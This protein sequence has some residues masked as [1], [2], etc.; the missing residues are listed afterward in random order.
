MKRDA[1]R[2]F[3][4]NADHKVV[5]VQ[6]I[7]TAF[8]VFLIGGGLAMLMRLELARHGLQFLTYRQYDAAA[9]A[10]GI[11]MVAAV[12]AAASGIGNFIVPLQLG[13][14]G[15]ALP[16]ANALGFWLFLSAVAALLTAPV[17]GGPLFL[18]AVVAA[19]LSAILGGVNMLATTLT[20]RAGGMD[21]RRVPIF[22]WSMIATSLLQVVCAAAL[23]STAVWLVLRPAGADMLA[24]QRLLRFCAHP[25]VYILLLPAFGAVLEILPAYCGKPLFARRP[26]AASL[27][28]IAAL[29]LVFG[30]CRILAPE[31][32]AIDAEWIAVPAGVVLLSALGTLWRAKIRLDAPMLWALAALANGLL[33]GLSGVPLAGA[34]IDL[35][36]RGTAFAAAHF[37]FTIMGVAVF[38]FLAAFH[39]WFP[40]MTGRRLNEALAKTQC[41][42]MFAGI[43]AVF[44]PL[45]WLGSHGMRRRA[46][47]FPA[48]MDPAQTFASSAALLIAA[49]ALVFIYNVC[50]S[51]ADGDAATEEPYDH[52]AQS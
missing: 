1:F 47:D 16:R 44:I 2:Y 14:R 22:A 41:A 40:M 3:S 11:A 12:F 38:G 27:L 37:H 19:C 29:S 45:F 39:H 35:P 50:R 31:A 25:A 26:A 48:W 8:A 4:F 49:S 34:P 46:A 51:M 24:Y 9:A 28:A 21:W 52:D 30:A 13:A 32:P 20:M 33:A 42:L 15:A 18:F 7:A 36:L 17:L 43:N 10:H 23:A 5:G 6:Y